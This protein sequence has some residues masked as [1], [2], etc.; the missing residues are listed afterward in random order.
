VNAF[1]LVPLNTII[2]GFH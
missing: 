2:R 1:V